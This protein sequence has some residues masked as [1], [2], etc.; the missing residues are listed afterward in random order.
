MSQREK[1]FL[2]ERSRAVSAGIITDESSGVVSDRIKVSRGALVNGVPTNT[3]V[4]QFD[5]VGTAIGTYGQLGKNTSTLNALATNDE[6][7]TF[8]EGKASSDM[9][10]AIT[11]GYNPKG[12]EILDQELDV[13]REAAALILLEG[14]FDVSQQPQDTTAQ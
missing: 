14:Q 6:L 12:R 4:A 5:A 11:G 7:S 2:V 8:L 13:A 1:L 9:P 10:E 3:L